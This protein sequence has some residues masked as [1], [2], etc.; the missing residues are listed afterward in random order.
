M[1]IST[2][3][4]RRAEDIIGWK[5]ELPIFRNSHRPK[6]IAIYAT[7]LRRVIQSKKGSDDLVYHTTRTTP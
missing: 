2:K 4:S 5:S 7:G 3:G 1:V 6:R